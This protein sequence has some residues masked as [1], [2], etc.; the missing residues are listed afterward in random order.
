[1]PCGILQL[2][3]IVLVAPFIP[4]CVRY[5]DHGNHCRVLNAT[6]HDRL[7]T[8]RRARRSVQL[9]TLPLPYLPFAP[10]HPSAPT[11]RRPFIRSFVCAD[12][13]VCVASLWSPTV[14]SSRCYRRTWNPELCPGRTIWIEEVLY[15]IRKRVRVGNRSLR[16]RWFTSLPIR[17]CPLDVAWWNG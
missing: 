8:V 7:T 1:M 2:Y 9:H 5:L 14:H 17:R 11:P 13:C 3:A 6:A 16:N 4:A 15:A 10:L 12:L